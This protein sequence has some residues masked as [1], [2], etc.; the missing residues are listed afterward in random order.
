MHLSAAFAQLT[1][2]LGSS[3]SVALL[4]I[5]SRLATFALIFWLSLFAAESGAQ[6]VAV[7][8]DGDGVNDQRE[9][10]DGTNPLDKTSFDPLSVKLVAHYPFDGSANDASGNSNHGTVSGAQL[11][12][13]RFGGTTKAYTFDGISENISVP[14]VPGFEGD[15]ISVSVWI[16]AASLSPGG[17][18]RSNI[19]EKGGNAFQW[20]L[21]LER[22]GKIRAAVITS[23][24]EKLLDSTAE[25]FTDA[26]HQ[27]VFTWNK[28]DLKI[29]IDGVLDSSVPAAGDMVQGPL[30]VII[31]GSNY[32]NTY[33][34]GKLDDVY[35]YNRELSAAEV[36]SL[37][38]V[39]DRS[40]EGAATKAPYDPATAVHWS[41]GGVPWLVDATT[42]HDSKDSI[43]AKT[44]DGQATYR[45][46]TVTGPAVV[47]FWWKVSSEKNYDTFSYSVDGAVRETIS[48]EVDWAYRTV[49][50]PAGS[51]V[52][53]WTYQKDAA[54]AVGADAGWLDDV[55]VY[56]A[57]P[58]LSVRQGGTLLT[59]TATVDFGFTGVGAAAVTRV[60]NFTNEGYVPMAVEL[61]LAV[62]SGFSFEGASTASLVLGRGESVAVP[63]SLATGSSGTKTTELAISVP[64]STVEPPRITLAGQILGPVI[65]VS[66]GSVPLASGQ[67]VDLG[68]APSSLELTITHAGSAGVLDISRVA[69]T[70][71]FEVAPLSTASFSPQNSA[72]FKVQARST[73]FGPQSGSLA[74]HSNDGDTPVFTLQLASQAYVAAEGGV[75]EGAVTTFGFGG[76]V[77][78]AFGSTRLPNDTTGPAAKTGAAPDNGSSV[79]EMVTQSAGILSW[80]WKVSAQQD[81][82]WLLCEVDGREVAGL[83]TKTAAWQSQV[84]QVP[85]Q[86]VVRWS[87]RKDGSASAGEDAGYLADVAFRSLAPQ[88]SFDTWA[89]PYGLT[90][91]Q[92]LL[93]SSGMPALFAWLGGFN[94]ATGP[95]SA[96]YAPLRDDGRLKFRF[97][98]SKSADGTQSVEFSEGLGQWSTRGLSQRLL[99]EDAATSTIEVVS[100]RTARGFFRVVGDTN[101]SAALTTVKGTVVGPEGDPAPGVT[102]TIQLQDGSF[103]QSTTTASNGSFSVPGV[104]AVGGP[105]ALSAFNT[106]GGQSSYFAVGNLAPNAAGITATGT[107]RLVL[108]RSAFVLIPEGS[109]QMG[110]ALDG[111]SDAPVR[112]VNVSAFIMAK[113]EVTKAEWDEVRSWGF[114]RGYTDLAVGGGKEGNHPVQMV[115]W[116]DVIKWCNARSEKDGLAPVYTF[117]GA[118]MRTGISVP[119][120]N[121]TARGYRLPTE[122][123]WEKSARGGLNGKRFPLGNTIT[124]SQ[125]NYYSES[126]YAYDISPTH[127]FH[128]T[129]AVG[130]QPYTSPVGSFAANGYGLYDMSG[131]LFEWCWDWYG[132]HDN[133]SQTDPRGV[134]SGAN[135]VFRG[136]S[137]ISPAFRCSVVD[138]DNNL[139]SNSYFSVGFRV[140]RSSVP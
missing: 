40:I 47:D 88:S 10:Y 84:V 85:A 70:G 5:S 37:F 124:H 109:F 129:Y 73:T 16:N 36:S 54:D 11:S 48:G 117:N 83:S 130:S 24:G 75:A 20:V 52:V 31:G 123:E 105:L 103:S 12:T 134:S 76:G 106:A 102:V 15:S 34:Q 23:S 125:G 68:L 44:T 86:A 57:E 65:G 62:G 2:S 53:R 69:T 81:F 120:A 115:T 104:P 119:T 94:P 67:S 121:W 25:I 140:V 118:V 112:T 35:I 29:Y 61:S 113:T 132:T 32:F 66:L 108:S 89:S 26:W 3:P 13:D 27:A 9:A 39:N 133:A 71:Q 101:S 50:V 91:P 42:S 135:R 63:V 77:G 126:A 98:A 51:H 49:T 87:Y 90:D 114:S 127:G 6:T 100:P 33:L 111:I 45:E 30:P 18:V 139:P 19:I 21:Q 1:R 64:G 38:V 60:L 95:E 46:Y 122:A 56:A 78:W 4:A 138:R 107:H 137:W 14:E 110:D 55:A 97:A 58:L 116:F 17:R 128:P 131:N 8:T 7:D 93:P 99:A 72:T 136:G 41:A 79:F 82:D 96:D 74:I 43:R 59:G 80:S 22:S 28:A 92:Q